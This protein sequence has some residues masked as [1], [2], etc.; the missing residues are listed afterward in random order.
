MA[1][2]H[3]PVRVGAPR[4]ILPPAAYDADMPPALLQRSDEDFIEATLEGLRTDTGRA[5]LKGKLAAARTSAQVLKLFQPV[6]RQFHLALVEAWCDTP[7]TPRIDPAKV[8]SAG[9][10]L[11]RIRTDASGRYLEGWVK[12]GGR[13][14][15]W[16]RVDRLGGDSAA[17]LSAQRLPRRPVS[18][19][20]D[21]ELA[22]L[23][24]EREDALLDEH[25]VPMFMTPPDVCAQAK[26]TLF[27]G[28][29]PTSS[30]EIADV[31]VD[32]AQ[33]FGE[34]FGPSSTSFRDH[35][36]EPLR[37]QAM[38][39]VLGG[40]TMHAGWF[41]AVEMPGADKPL[42]LPDDHWATLVTIGGAGGMKRFILLLRQLA[43]E[44]DAFGE[45]AEG[46]AVFAALEAIR[47]P[48]KLRPFEVTPRT[49]AAGTF[50]KLA[51]RVLLERDPTA[52]PPEMPMSWPA[53]DAAA[54]SHLANALSG[55]L[56]KRFSDMKGQPGRFDELGAQYVLRAFVRLRP[57]GVC[58]AR[59]E[60]SAYS[61]PFVIAPWYEGAGA[62]PVQ[63]PLPDATD[64]N[65]LKS[66]R[67]N[68][69]FVVPPS[70]QNLLSGNPK[71]ML[72]GK[73]STGGLTLGWICGFNIPIITICAFIVL[74]IF[75]SL[76]DLIF[77]WLFFIKICIPF[78]KRS[79]E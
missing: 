74:N 11:R 26:K 61:E 70:L 28:L 22:R 53:L 18:P 43:G 62:A 33:A 44:F 30:A 42:G 29:V 27:Y 68:V 41:E 24:L 15:G 35:L 19:S 37:G 8:D 67:P 1:M 34:D 5:E 36:V 25:V 23:A 79:D 63:V 45:S 52:A 54:R 55:A 12:S 13:L 6:Q 51:S 17:P 49:V 21:R 40:E 73:G 75:L 69:A 72:E 20:I 50:L 56:A 77:R 7:G 46:K 10:V 48:L 47:L 60:W 58:P 64:R 39:F 4:D 38:N 32:P 78:P 59:T 65:V 31:P 76:F 2:R 16:A 9:L 3:H 14:R 66:L 57:D 71:D